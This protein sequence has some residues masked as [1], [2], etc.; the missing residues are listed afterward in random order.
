[1][2]EFVKSDHPE[3]ILIKNKTYF[4]D[5]GY[6][7]EIYRKNSF[8]NDGIDCEFVQDNHSFSKREV[9]RGLHYQSSFPQGKLLQV[10]NGEIFDVA[11][12]LRKSSSLFGS[13]VGIF[14]NAE[15]HASLWIPPGFAHGFYTLSESAN[16]LYKT[17]EYYHPECDCSIR[18]NDPDLTI[19]WPLIDGR[20]PILSAKDAQAPLFETAQV[21]P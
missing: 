2:I 21:F 12:D 9:L 15:D 19:D 11:V 13:W 20:P 5:R 1:M 8:F 3:V 6:F 7:H 18:W 10:I 4:D 14:L 16:L 17:D